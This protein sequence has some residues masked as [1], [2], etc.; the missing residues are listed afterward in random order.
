MAWVALPGAYTPA[1]ITLW[2]IGVRK[3]LLCDKAVVVEVAME[4]YIQEL[5]RSNIAYGIRYYD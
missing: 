4:G 1:S 2:I 5:C 3:P